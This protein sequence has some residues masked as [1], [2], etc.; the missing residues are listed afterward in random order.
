MMTPAKELNGSKAWITWAFGVVI[1]AIT[2]LSTNVIANDRIR[3]AEDVRLD[4]EIALAAR[5]VAT[6][7][8]C[9]IGMKDDLKEIKSIL[10][11]TSPYE[12]K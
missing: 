11:R 1:T 5:N 6:L 4:R 7:Q 12:R 3:A 10:K 2:M 9:I 8:E